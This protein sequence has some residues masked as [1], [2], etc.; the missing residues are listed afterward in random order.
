M[1]NVEGWVTLWI[2]EAYHNVFD[3]FTTVVIADYIF[4]Y[5]VGSKGTI[6]AW[7]KVRTIS[8]KEFQ[9]L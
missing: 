5:W 9:M 1:K 2:N 7:K 4:N 6:Y 3:A 8:F